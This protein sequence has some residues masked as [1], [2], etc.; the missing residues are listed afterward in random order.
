RQS[1]GHVTIHSEAGKGTTV[2]LYLPRMQDD[3][4]ASDADAAGSGTVAT[5]VPEGRREETVLV[6]EDDA[7]VRAYSTEAL[8]ELGYGV[9]EAPDGPAALR[10]LER[11]HRVDLLFT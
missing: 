8:R 6:V 7:D 11:E 9:L 3:A 2:K 1:G 10:L 5:T 4:A